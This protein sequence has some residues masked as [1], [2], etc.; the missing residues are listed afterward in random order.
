MWI[1]LAEKTQD[2]N[3]VYYYNDYLKQR[4]ESEREVSNKNMIELELQISGLY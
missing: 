1:V 2:T 3:S 4:L